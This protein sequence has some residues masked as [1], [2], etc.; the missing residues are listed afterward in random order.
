MI[1]WDD[2][3]LEKIVHD[4]VRDE[5]FTLEGQMCEYGI[6][7]EDYV[8]FAKSLLRKLEKRP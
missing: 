1:K 3:K 7:M 4:L 5:Q 6:D 2:P 8:Q